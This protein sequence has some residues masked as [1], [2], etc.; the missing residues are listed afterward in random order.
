MS[1]T[2]ALSYHIIGK[3]PLDR[4][5]TYRDL[6]GLCKHIGEVGIGAIDIA[7]WDL[8]G[9]KYNCSIMELLG[10]NRNKLVAYAST[11]GGDREKNGLSSP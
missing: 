9:K 10:G 3:N 2:Q 4:L 5:S 11:M 6:R 8:A 1:A 7:L